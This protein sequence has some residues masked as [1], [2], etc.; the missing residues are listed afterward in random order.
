MSDRDI[1]IGALRFDD[2]DQRSAYLDGACAGDDA[3]RSRVDALL[4]AVDNAGPLHAPPAPGDAGS[5]ADAPKFSSEAGDGHRPPP[6]AIKEGP[7][8]LIGPYKLL[9][10]IGE[11]GMGIVYMAEQEQPVHRK[12]ALKIIKPGMDSEQVIARFEAERQ[13]LALMDHPN[14]AKVLDA[15]TTE[16]GRPYFVMELV[17]GVPITNFCDE[18]HLT[19]RERLELFVPICQAIQHAHQKGII[20]RDLKPSN[21]LLAL[22]DD[23]R[24]PKVIDFGVAKATGERLT[25]R[26]LF[27]GF[28]AIVGTPDY[29]SPEQARLN[30]LDIDTRTDIYSL[31]VLLYELLTGGMPF[32]RLRLRQASLDEMLRII[33]D[34]DPPRP[35]T[36][37]SS[38]DRLATLAAQRKTDPARLR[39]LIRGELDWI[40]MKALEKDRS[41]RYETAVAFAH[42]VERYLTGDPVEAGAPSTV[43]R[44]SKIAR[45]YRGALA[46]ASAIAVLLLSA[47]AVSSV[48]A[49]KATREERRATLSASETKAVLSFFQK[50]VVGA[51]RSESGNGGLGRQVT[52]RQALDAAE[53]KIGAFFAGQPVL[54]A[55][56]R[57]ALGEGYR[58]LS[59][60]ELAIRQLEPAFSFRRQVLG[61]DD[62]DTLTS[63]NL[64]AL[65]YQDMG[66]L[67]EAI[68]IFE[69]TLRRRRATLGSDHA[70]TLI[71]MNNLASAYYDAD[72]LP[73]ALHLYEDA[74]RR[75]KA[76]L[77]PDHID[78]LMSIDNLATAYQRAHRLD[79]A[80]PLFEEAFRG[81]KAKLGPDQ[82]DT[83][84][85]MN[86]LANAYR[87]HGQ[88][89]DALSLYEG[90]LK[91]QQANLG[92]EETD[93]LR[94]M[95]N[96]ARIYL[97]DK[98][99]EAEKLMRKAL[100]IQ[101][102][103]KQGDWRIFDTRSLLG[104]SLMG[105]KRYAEA[106]RFLVQG[107]D[108]LAAHA[109]NSTAVPKERITEAG[110]RIVALYNDWGKK[111]IAEEWQSAS[112]WL[113]GP[114]SER[115]K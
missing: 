2:R 108:G 79:E 104:A 88:L 101:E 100:E 28:G 114:R 66:R 38:S 20:H 90:L 11:G 72:R 41:R 29:M 22:Y 52:L 75:S 31:G 55:S 68:P 44:L 64:V 21:V 8:S 40:V 99:A 5:T 15:A 111:E 54:E 89:A 103:K 65:T 107:Y 69:D 4:Q 32:D 76:I 113:C 43:Y 84:I 53:P 67:A 42:D 110:A 3:L 74:L 45:R 56:I 9:Q 18:N 102:N 6:W 115:H 98:P 81:Y 60:P 27:T 70:D 30:A 78:T 73:E 36:R 58:Q 93:T 59:E 106:E 91:R 23:R 62:P 48:L 34:E 13:A 1:L 97:G 92:S 12:V 94:T 82:V 49:I 19:T 57:N 83:L 71:S 39:R 95:N 105:Q 63:M 86:N 77:G 7:G 33:R 46:T 10:K 16:S 35:S 25:D 80:L 112:Q 26:T 14:I 96:L 47:A 87:D 37:L 85:S 24:V 61:P 51:M 109:G 50:H 17:R